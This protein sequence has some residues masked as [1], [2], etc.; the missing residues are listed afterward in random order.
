MTVNKEHVTFVL[1][2]NRENKMKKENKKRKTKIMKN[3]VRNEK[4]NYFWESVVHA[5]FVR[6]SLVAS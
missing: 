4:N 6:L 2:R 5:E 3:S 1:W